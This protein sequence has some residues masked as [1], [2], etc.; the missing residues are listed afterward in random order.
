VH[1]YTEIFA[2]PAVRGRHCSIRLD[3]QETRKILPISIVVLISENRVRGTDA[4]VPPAGL[5][6]VDLRECLV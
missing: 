1:R 6:E 3:P 4:Q 5:V 2:R